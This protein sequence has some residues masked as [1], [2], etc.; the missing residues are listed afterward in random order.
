MSKKT[1]KILLIVGI[2]LFVV[3]AAT[4]VVFYIIWPTQT[5]DFIN[6]AWN[7]VNQPLPVLGF[8]TL[9]IGFLALRIIASTSIGKKLY[10]ETIIRVGDVEIRLLNTANRMEELVAEY[11]RKIAIIDK[12]LERNE[13]IQK[14]V[15]EAIPN[16]KVKAIGVKYYGEERQEETHD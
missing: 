13:L 5:K 4:V 8:S 14:E 12:F 2:S 6:N 16:K 15:I 11:E 10:N 9:M 1:K 3:I 7:W